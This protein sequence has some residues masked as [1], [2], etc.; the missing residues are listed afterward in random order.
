MQ[1]CKGIVFLQQSVFSTGV[2]QLS[3]VLSTGL[4]MH[5]VT[6]VVLVRTQQQEEQDN[7]CVRGQEPKP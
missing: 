5:T 1:R 6:V 7:I 3:V 4:G 2:G